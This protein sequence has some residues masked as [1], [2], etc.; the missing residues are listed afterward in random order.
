MENRRKY[1][2]NNAVN[3]VLNNLQPENF[4]EL[5]NAVR[6]NRLQETLNLR[7]NIIG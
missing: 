5:T 3:Y 4:E 6:I 7:T 1:F 2:V